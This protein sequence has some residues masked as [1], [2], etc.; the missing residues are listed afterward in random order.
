MRVTWVSLLVGVSFGLLWASNTFGPSVEVILAPNIFPYASPVTGGS[1]DLPFMHC[2]DAPFASSLA[3]S[4][5]LL[6]NAI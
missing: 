4:A 6:R 3:N 2:L 1:R 5:R